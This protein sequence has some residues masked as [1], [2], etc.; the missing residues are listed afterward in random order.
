MTYKEY[1]LKRLE[2]RMRYVIDGMSSYPLTKGETLKLNKG[3]DMLNTI[4][5]IVNGKLRIPGL[6]IKIEWLKPSQ[7]W[8]SSVYDLPASTED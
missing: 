4:T 2:N 1:L 5:D 7:T 3:L 6:V 8:S